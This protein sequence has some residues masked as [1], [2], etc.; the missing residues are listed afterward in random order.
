MKI[1]FPQ[2]LCISRITV[3]QMFALEIIIL[4]FDSLLFLIFTI[5]QILS[6]EMFIGKMQM[7]LQ[8]SIVAII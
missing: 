8:T 7:I 3:L 5:I 4:V 1:L 2:M 6:E